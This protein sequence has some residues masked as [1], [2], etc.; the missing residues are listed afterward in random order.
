MDCKTNQVTINNVDHGSWE[1][2]LKSVGEACEDSQWTSKYSLC[3]TNNTNEIRTFVETS[4]DLTQFLR[5]NGGKAAVLSAKVLRCFI[6]LFSLFFCQLTTPPFCLVLFS[7]F[8][9]A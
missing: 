7:F 6:F 8:G 9:F 5:K 4:Q 1:K 2:I 3:T